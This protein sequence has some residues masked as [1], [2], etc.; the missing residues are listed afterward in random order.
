MTAT[1]LPIG[2]APRLATLENRG[3]SGSSLGHRLSR[4]LRR[5]V[6]SSAGKLADSETETTAALLTRAKAGDAGALDDLFQRYMGP[7]KRWAHGRLPGWA[8]DLR[9]TDDLVQES[10]M[11]TLRQVHRFEPRR[12]GAFL[13]YLRTALQNK[14]KDEIRRARRTRREPLATDHADAGPSVVEQVIG[15]QVLERYER[16]LARLSV[17]ERE[18][19]LGRIEL[20]KSYAEIAE[21]LEKPSPD[22]ARM[23]VTRALTKL[24]LEMRRG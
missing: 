23:T 21:V 13:A 22:A 8:R 14:L 3:A 6:V 7:L 17:E 5:W 10:V 15:R 24:A 1:T 20:G 2:W 19:V 18:A 16:A 4:R 9:D 12:D 11:H